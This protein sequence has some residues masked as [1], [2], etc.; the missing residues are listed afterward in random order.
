M[1]LFAGLA[2]LVVLATGVLADSPLARDS[3]VTV[4]I[5]KRIDLN[6]IPDFIK[7][8]REHLRNLVKRGGHRR[9]FSTANK[10]PSVLLNNN[11]S[12]YVAT[13]GIGEPATNCESCKFLPRKVSYTLTQDRLLVDSG[14]AM[15][16][17][18]ADKHR[19]YVKTKN[20]VNTKMSV[21]SIAPHRLMTKLKLNLVC[22][23]ITYD[24]GFF[25]GNFT[26]QEPVW[27]IHVLSQVFCTMIQLRFPKVST[28]LSN[29]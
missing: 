28:L 29:T 20:S 7:R 3:L 11:G 8:D 19:D 16:W 23:N 4:P 25:N 9:Q 18:G 10:T 24:N 13:I 17:V 5:S 26:L 15:T 27:Y 12:I 6:G 14:S 22:Q 21:V 2:P 1:L